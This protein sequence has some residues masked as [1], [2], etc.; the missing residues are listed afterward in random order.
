MKNFLFFTIALVFALS[1]KA[2]ANI[3]DNKFGNEIARLKTE[4]YSLQKGYI[5]EMEQTCRGDNNYVAY[6]S[7]YIS[8]RNAYRNFTEDKNSAA[9]QMKDFLAA[10]DAF[11]VA[12][13]AQEEM[14]CEIEASHEATMTSLYGKCYPWIELF[15]KPMTRLCR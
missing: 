13:Q 4:F 9:K 12:D 10:V 1:A 15:H 14:I 8:L 6:V 2:G 3:P 7:K 5:T 11:E